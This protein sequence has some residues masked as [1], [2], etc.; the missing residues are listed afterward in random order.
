[1]IIKVAVD[2]VIYQRAMNKPDLFH[3]Q[4]IPL[5]ERLRIRAGEQVDSLKKF[6][7]ALPLLL[8]SL[9]F[10][11]GTLVLTILITEW[12]S[13]VY[14]GVVLLLNLALSSCSLFTVV[15]KTE[16]KLGLTYKFLKLSK[17]LHP[18]SSCGEHVVPQG[19]PR[20]PPPAN[21]VPRQHRHLVHPRRTHLVL[22]KQPHPSPEHLPH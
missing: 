14:I 21:Q 12:F 5:K 8:T 7:V 3:K 17:P 16:K 20:R 13:A 11:S 1:M 19:H 2:I 10:H 22:S 9:V 4:A 18:S 6:L 15:Q